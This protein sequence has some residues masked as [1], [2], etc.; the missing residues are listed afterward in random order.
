VRGFRLADGRF[1]EDADG[2]ARARVAVLGARTTE[3]LFPGGGALGATVR[4]RGIP[5]EVIGVLHPRGTSLGG[6]DD[7]TELFVPVETA[8][9]RLYNARALSE[10][11]ATVAEPEGLAQG[12]DAIRRLVR[13]RHR[14]AAFGRPDDFAVQDQLQAVA[15][16]REAARTLGFAS[17]GLAAIS[18]LVGGTGILGLMLLSVAERTPEIGLRMALG[19]RPRYVLVQFLAEAV[20]LAA[21]GGGVGV[22]LGGVGAWAISAA[23]AWPA[24]PSWQAAAAAL[25]TSALLG[26]AAGV[27]PA[28]R[29]AR[30]P[31]ALALSRG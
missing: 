17:S 14:T 24:R 10:L 12:E 25:A 19:A 9:R 11:Y 3:L 8:L 4:V 30:L 2:A 18:L 26:L 29:A 22:V 13:A 23:T 5:F 7:D 16:Q 28:V 21:A 20:V 27:L 1:L 6:A 31:P 15:M